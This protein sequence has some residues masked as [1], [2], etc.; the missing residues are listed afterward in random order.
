V[1]GFLRIVGVINAAVWFGATVFL[2]FFVGPAFFSESMLKLFGEA[3][4]RFYAGAAA[5]IVLERYFYLQLGCSILALVHLVAEC[6]YLG[7]PLIR[8]TLSLLGALLVLAAVGGYGLQPKLRTLHW[9]KYDPRVSVEIRQVAERSFRRWHGV[10]QVL[11]L[12]ALAGVTVYLLRVTRPSDA[13]RYR[14]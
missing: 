3:A 4:G 5:Q 12:V 10:S 14:G 7:R 13:S 9:Q 11:N 6:V 2:T 1:I 8:W